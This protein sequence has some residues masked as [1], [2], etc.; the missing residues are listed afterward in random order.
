MAATVPFIVGAISLIAGAGGGLYWILAGIIG[1]VCS[2]AV[3][4]WVLP[5][6]ILR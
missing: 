5:I 3:N 1:A 6:E 4:A 2:S